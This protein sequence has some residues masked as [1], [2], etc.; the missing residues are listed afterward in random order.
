MTSV[1]LMCV[2]Q[3]HGGMLLFDSFADVRQFQ[4]VA[5]AALFIPVVLWLRHCE[6]LPEATL[7]I[8]GGRNRGVQ[9]GKTDQCLRQWFL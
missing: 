4:N 3:V 9:G 7:G 2:V 6:V 1:L 5:R 8:D